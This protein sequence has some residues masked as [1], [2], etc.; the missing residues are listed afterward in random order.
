MKKRMDEVVNKKWKWIAAFVLCAIVLVGNRL[1]E[2][3]QLNV[4]VKKIVYSSEDLTMMRNLLREVFGSETD[5]TIT[6]SSE[7]I[8]QELLSFV[9]VKPFDNGYLLTYEQAIPI[10]AIENGLVVYTGHSKTTGKTISVFYEDDTTITYGNV[11][12]FSLL[13]YT[14]IERGSTIANKEIG[15]L[16]IKIEKDGKV[17]NLEETLEWMKEHTQS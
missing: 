5:T 6:V 1:Q 4:D 7:T 14:S 13:P 17:L 8:N 10:L 3:G 9:A 15:D 12:S 2:N 11:D 16:Y